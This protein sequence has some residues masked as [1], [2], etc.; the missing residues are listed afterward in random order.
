MGGLKAVNDKNGFTLIELLI[1]VAI[2]G[3]LASIAIPGYI[4]SQEKSRKSVIIKAGRASESDMQHWINSAIKGA[5]PTNPAALLIEVDTDWNGAVTAVDCTNLNLFNVDGA[6]AA[7]AAALTYSGARF[8][9]TPCGAAGV[10]MNGAETSPWAGMNACAPLAPLFIAG[11]D[12]GAGNPGPACQVLLAP[13]GANTVAIVTSS[14][15]PGGSNSAGA[16]LMT[17]MVIAS[18]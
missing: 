5:V 18:Q 16:E 6:N 13:T 9:A 3:I 11:V 8:N 10:A 7:N 15:G 2:I 14:N 17:R 1:V 12:P 4:G